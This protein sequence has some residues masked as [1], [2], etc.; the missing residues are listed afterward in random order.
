MSALPPRCPLPRLAA[1]AAASLTCANAI[2][3]RLALYEKPPAAV[4]AL[5]A[6]AALTAAAVASLLL[7]PFTRRAAAVGALS[8]LPV[9]LAAQSPGSGILLL[10]LASYVLTPELLSAVAQLADGWLAGN[11]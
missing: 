5:L 7:D 3:A 10:A 2:L 1:A 11:E 6:S 9:L 4:P 8:A